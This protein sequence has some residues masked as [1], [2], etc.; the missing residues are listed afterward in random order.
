MCEQYEEYV[1]HALRDYAKTKDILQMHEVHTRVTLDQST[2]C[3]QWLEHAMQILTIEDFTKPM[4]PMTYM[5]PQK[6][7]HGDNVPPP[8]LTFLNARKLQKEFLGTLSK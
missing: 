5:E 4:V 2:T 6:L 3:Q 7:V 8:W 1:I